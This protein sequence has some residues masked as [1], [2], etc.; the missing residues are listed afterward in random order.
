MVE[1]VGCGIPSQVLDDCL[2]PALRDII[3]DAKSRANDAHRT[4]AGTEH[5]LSAIL[6]SPC[7]TAVAILKDLEL[8]L[9]NFVLPVVMR[10]VLG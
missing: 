4:L 8:I 7:C 1:L 2:T 9:I 6:H 10:I 5:L 3:E